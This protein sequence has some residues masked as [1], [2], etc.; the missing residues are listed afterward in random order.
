[1]SRYY[2]ILI[3]LLLAA[4]TSATSAQST[5]NI[6]RTDEDLT[7]QHTQ[8]WL[9]AQ[10]AYKNTIDQVY[11]TLRT[12]FYERLPRGEM[13]APFHTLADDPS[14]LQQ[15][16]HS[17]M[18]A[19]PDW[20]A[21]ASL[22]KTLGRLHAVNYSDFTCEWT[23]FPMPASLDA[24]AGQI[25]QLAGDI[26][27]GYHAQLTQG[28]YDFLRNNH[29]LMMGL[30]Q[31]YPFGGA[32]SEDNLLTL[33]EYTDLLNSAD[34][35]AIFCLA[36]QWSQFQEPAWRNKVYQ[37]M[38]N[39]ENADSRIIREFS[40]AYGRIIF[41]G[42]GELRLRTG[43]LLFLADLGGDDIYALRT[44]DAWSG[45]PQLIL[46]FAG[47]DIYDAQMPGGYAAGIGTISLLT[48]L[49][50]DDSY[51]A[52]SQSQGTGIFGVG[53]L[54]DLA[55]NDEYDARTM[56]QGFSFFG[57]GMLLDEAGHDRYQVMGLGQGVGMTS[58]LGVMVDAGGDDVYEATGLSPTSYGT[59]GLSD[60]WSQG[61]GVGVRFMTPGGI[62]ILEDIAGQDH[63]TAGSFS[64]GGGY[65]LG[66]GLFRDGGQ[67]DDSYLGSRYNFGWGAHMGVSYFLEEGG[68][69]DYRTRQFVA[70]GLSWD[71][72]MVLFEDHDGDDRYVMG[73]FSIGAA[74]HRSIVLFHDFA[75]RDTYIDDM[76]ARANQGPPSLAV[77]IDSG[78]DENTFENPVIT[79]TCVVNNQLGFYFIVLSMTGML[80]GDCLPE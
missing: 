54:H 69:D 70:S 80:S 13:A 56:A 78:S 76:P 27:A 62:G 37:L 26:V 57:A 31:A 72:S 49:A 65:Y 30:I 46:D 19:L 47:N 5:I 4:T 7:L 77:F 2:H 28:Q 75:G 6:P 66:L 42:T 11:D 55:G 25:E 1:L 16:L 35:P 73:G 3:T 20:Q 29:P 60:S 15:T 59:P 53:I 79:G 51:H 52:N 41:G 36:E 71:R 23:P 43:N 64:Q 58:A 12:V 24:A 38:A 21:G 50:G 33:G 74:A 10:P 40:T 17:S 48:D 39:A 45:L 14:R 68:N 18:A 22:S 9:A 32:F 63:Y 8:D 44:L 67:A 34:L 61:I